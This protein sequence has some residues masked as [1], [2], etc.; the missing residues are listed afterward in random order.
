MERRH[1]FKLTA[2][3]L[4]GLTVADAAPGAAAAQDKKEPRDGAFMMFP[5]NYT[6]SAA[7]RRHR[8]LALG[9]IGSRGGPPQPR[10]EPAS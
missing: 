3:G 10:S 1:L 8:D 6:W 9:R 4:A 7:I 5:G 2:A